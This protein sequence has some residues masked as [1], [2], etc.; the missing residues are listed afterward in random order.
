MLG[1]FCNQQ[2]HRVSALVG[3]SFIVLV[4]DAVLVMVHVMLMHFAMVHNSHFNLS[5]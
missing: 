1:K 2:V 4:S 3:D 5:Q